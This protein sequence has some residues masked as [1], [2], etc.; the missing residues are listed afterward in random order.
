MKAIKSACVAALVAVGV[1]SA[2]ALEL[3]GSK[4]VIV[5]DFAR[6]SQELQEILSAVTGLKVPVC[7]SAQAAKQDISD[8]YVWRIAVDAGKLGKEECAWTIGEKGA[9]IVG[10]PNHGEQCG[11]YDCMEE[12]LGVRFPWAGAIA[13]DIGTKVKVLKTSGEWKNPYRIRA[14]RM[15]GLENSKWRWR[16]RDGKHDYP[17]YGHAFSRYWERFGATRLH[18][19][20]FAMRTD[21]KRMP[22][23]SEERRVGKECRS[24]WSPYH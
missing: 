18:P 1:F 8:K 10:G 4:F 5:S 12:G 16:M 21:G 20:Y 7:T 22:I 2:S 13:C 19:E 17:A 3:D 9:L 11:V 24:R 15:R 14:I 6:A 23:R